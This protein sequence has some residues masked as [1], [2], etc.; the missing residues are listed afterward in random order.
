MPTMEP[1]EPLEE[2]SRVEAFLAPLAEVSPASRADGRR[3]A[4]TRIRRLVVIAV[5]LVALGAGIA[6]AAE[7]DPTATVIDT[8]GDVTTVPLI[9]LPPPADCE[10]P[11]C[12][13]AG[14]DGHQSRAHPEH[15]AR[16]R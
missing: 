1:G 6:V 5:L 7:N 15:S 16:S 4:R 11:S 8:N 14:A 2:E 3:R 9:P 12:S 13:N 10:N